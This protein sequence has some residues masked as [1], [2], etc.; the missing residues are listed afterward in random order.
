[1]IFAVHHEWESGMTIKLLIAEDYKAVRE[2]LR[3]LFD[4]PEVE[5]RSGSPH[6]ERDAAACCEG[7]LRGR[8]AR[9]MRP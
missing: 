9:S 2:G 6:G 5:D 8:S 7:K 4:G 1:M 3:V